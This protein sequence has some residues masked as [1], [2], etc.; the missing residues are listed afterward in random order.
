MPP[1]TH[2]NVFTLCT[3][4]CQRPIK[5]PR[6]VNNCRIVATLMYE[7]TQSIDTL[8]GLPSVGTLGPGDLLMSNRNNISTHN[9]SFVKTTKPQP[10]HKPL[11]VAASTSLP[12]KM[13]TSNK[14]VVTDT[15]SMK[16][17]LGA[18]T[19]PAAV[20]AAD[21]AV[22]GGNAHAD[23]HKSSASML[24]KPVS[25]APPPSSSSGVLSNFFEGLLTKST[26]VCCEWM[27]VD[28]DRCT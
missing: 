16:A 15:T 19:G 20:V 21:A 5:K 23:M 17:S 18:T 24:P 1:Y 22:T 10:M 8:C 12:T 25:E 27:V 28:V 6:V 7:L 2:S 3:T 14:I 9:A 11:P 26:Q 4:F 13:T